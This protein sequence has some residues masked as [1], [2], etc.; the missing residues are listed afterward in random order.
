[1]RATYPLRY[2]GALENYAKGCIVLGMFEAGKE[3]KLRLKRGVK[4]LF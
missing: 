2:L 4:N 1:M 3:N